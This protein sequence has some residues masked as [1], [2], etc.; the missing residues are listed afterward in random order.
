MKSSIVDVVEKHRTPGTSAEKLSPSAQLQGYLA[1]GRATCA[2]IYSSCEKF[3]RL[4]KGTSSAAF[5]EKS[6]LSLRNVRFSRNAPE[7][8]E[9]SSRAFRCGVDSQSETRL[10]YFLSIRIGARILKLS[11]LGDLHVCHDDGSTVPRSRSADLC[12]LSLLGFC[13][14]RS[15]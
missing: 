3:A 15:D 5:Y 11:A 9:K 13:S 2:E 4:G 12:L 8:T 7:R 6:L 1:S 14:F 10:Q